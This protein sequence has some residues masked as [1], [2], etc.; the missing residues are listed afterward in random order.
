MFSLR[1]KKLARYKTWDCGYQAGS[2]RMQYTSSSFAEPF[3]NIFS[4]LFVRKTSLKLPSSIFPKESHFRLK[5]S[6]SLEVY[7]LE[8]IIKSLKSF[9][10]KFLWIQNGNTQIYILYGFVFLVLSI[11]GIFIYYK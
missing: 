6:D 11:I 8:R 1:N 4:N 2:R 7:F 3:L 10:S 9:L 5:L